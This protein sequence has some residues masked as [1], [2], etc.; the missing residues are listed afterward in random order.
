MDTLRGCD[1]V[2]YISRCFCGCSEG[3]VNL[4]LC[5]DC[6]PQPNLTAAALVG[7]YIVAG[8]SFRSDSATQ[9]LAHSIYYFGG[10]WPRPS[11]KRTV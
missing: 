5:L 7:I 10:R 2:L 1:W 11:L 4:P 6:A 9:Q 3:T 8:F